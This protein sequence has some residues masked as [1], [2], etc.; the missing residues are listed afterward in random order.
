[1]NV[2][3]P[4]CH[5]EINISLPVVP[6]GGVAITCP[7]CRE[8]FQFTGEESLEEG[9]SEVLSEAPSSAP[10]QAEEDSY[11]GLA[12]F[13]SEFEDLAEEGNEAQASDAVSDPLAGLVAEL[14]QMTA[15]DDDED[16]DETTYYVKRSGGK[17]FGPFGVATIQE[18]L[19]KGQLSGQEELSPDGDFW[20][21]MV[22]W[23]E[24]R[25]LLLSKGLNAVT[26]TEEEEEAEPSSLPQRPSYEEKMASID[27]TEEWDIEDLKEEVSSVQ[28]AAQKSKGSS[29][30]GRKRKDEKE[31]AQNIMTT[32][33]GV[34]IA[35]EE[36]DEPVSPP[37]RAH[38]G[39][40]RSALKK[41][42]L[43]R[44][45]AESEK[46]L[47]KI[48]IIGGAIGLLAIIG[49]VLFFLFSSE[50]KPSH[51]PLITDQSKAFSL[52]SY[53]YYRQHLLPKFRNQAKRYPHNVDAQIHYALALLATLENYRPLPKLYK[54]LKQIIEKLP[55]KK[56]DVPQTPLRLKVN[57]LFAL[58][59]GQT[60]TALQW[61]NDV[62]QTS[63]HY[64]V[65][66]Y[67]K[68]KIFYLQ[69]RYKA[70]LSPLSQLLK[71]FPQH[72]R[73]HYLRGLCLLKLKK[74]KAAFD[75]FYKATLASKQ[76]LPSY[77]AL[78]RLEEKVP[79]QKIRYQVIKKTALKIF[80]QAQHSRLQNIFY[81]LQAI[82]AE[83]KH[84]YVRA[85]RWFS[86]ALK[87]NPRD[88]LALKRK[89]LIIFLSRHYQK[90]QTELLNMTKKRNP[91]AAAF[92]LR[93]LHR[94]QNWSAAQEWFVV[95]MKKYKKDPTI[96]YWRAFIEFSQQRLPLAVKY[97]EKS[98]I[99]TDDHYLPAKV[100][101]AI[102]FWKMKKT[103]QALKHWEKIQE[104]EAALLAK[105]KATKK[106]RTRKK[107][108]LLYW[109]FD[110][111]FIK[112]EFYRISGKQEKLLSLLNKLHRQYKTDELINGYLGEILLQKQEYEKSKQYFL[113]ALKIMPK[114]LKAIKGLALVHEQLAELQQ[115]AQYYKKYIKLNT[116]DGE[117]YF[118]L[119]RVYFALKKYKK[120]LEN[121]RMAQNLND[122]IA[123]LHYYKARIFEFQKATPRRIQEAYERAIELAPKKRS[124]LY[125]FARFLSQRGKLERAL[126]I[127]TRLLR[128]RQQTKQQKAEVY[129][130][131]GKLFLEVKMARQAIR[132]FKKV[133]RLD[134]KAKDIMAY[135][136]DAY[137][138]IRRYSQAN[139]WYKKY[140]RILRRKT[141]EALS[142]Q[143]KQKWK[144]IQAK[145]YGKL[146]QL[147]QDRNRASQA[148]R[149]YRMALRLNPQAFQYYRNLGY[150]YK[151]R[152][153]WSSCIRA[154]RKF[155]KKA[156]PNHMDRREV[157]YDLRG[158]QQ[159]QFGQ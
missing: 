53:A 113:A 95:N 110:L 72:A 155:L 25:D 78:L 15:E 4:Y 16:D 80:A 24:F 108:K 158:C 125:H 54:T 23:S 52:D 20:S 130:E 137:A 59:R 128:N 118:R 48:A 123:A 79:S 116:L 94:I 143:E 49:V 136:G 121:L 105:Q 99:L 12:D 6:P 32:S 2:T 14:E 98:A 22:D 97:I 85:N 142:P 132:D 90:G 77:I 57:A 11:S 68:G 66:L 67:T 106:K 31:D 126:A 131:R 43:E 159:A 111:D 45:L 82:Q 153:R 74:W 63:P 88:R 70:A 17:T 56:K 150:L 3:C 47:P 124:Y 152:K 64:F 39:V 87:Y 18:M 65:A 5:N 101:E 96:W 89:P 69:H 140:L 144:L 129:F 1:M 10:P 36:P 146:G 34:M 151:D 75:D 119:G 28:E 29:L 115:A 76:H 41:E 103:K 135:L 141:K 148:I 62:S 38:Q 50:K 58:Y 55:P 71:K 21:P 35:F 114:N 102:I 138:S 93:V 42:V 133:Y 30:F 149:Y 46:K 120:S 145:I 139:R 100:L 91:T 60:H 84:D 51:I 40:V 61:A 73:G 27:E 7:K 127:Y 13:V 157:T 92:Y 44:E 112:V 117:I 134:R 107:A 83:K 156:P 147:H 154:F 9:S 109:P 8:S 33:D 26:P 104:E 37:K 19:E 122:K 81:R 86:L